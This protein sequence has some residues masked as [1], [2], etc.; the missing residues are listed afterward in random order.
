MLGQVVVD[1]QDVLALVHEVLAHSA[2]GIGGDILQGR[3]LGGGGRNYDGVLH[4]AGLG[5][6]LDQVCHSRALLAD[7]DVNADDVL[8]L[9]VDDGIGGDH[10]L[11]GLAVA[12]DQLA[13]AAAD[14]DHGVD[15][16]DAGLEGLFDRLAVD[17]AGGRALDGPVLSRFDGAC[18]VDGLAQG[19]DHAA[20]HALA[21]RHRD[22]P[23]GAL[24][25]AALF[26]AGVRAQQN[27]GDGV[28]LQ[29]LGHAV[30]AV[31]ELEQLAGHAGVQTAGA[32]D[33]VAHHD[34]GAGLALLD[35]RLV[36]FDL[37]A[38]DFRDLLWFQLHLFVFTTQFF[39]FSGGSFVCR[40]RLT[41]LPRRCSGA[42]PPDGSS[43]C[44]PAAR[45]PY[46]GGCRPARPGQP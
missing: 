30:L 39:L 27:D 13:L 45:R 9:L 16:L 6:G 17:D 34:D 42:G 36:V 41:G 33:A 8:A 43:R 10:R 38:D 22:N 12:N 11:T 4:G 3:Q 44:R 7:G 29:V 35:H 2:A 28:L 1:D 46:P 21:H 32:G 26:D 19:V 15:G 5:Q 23:A 31:L 14:G 40:T 18:A 25:H 24:D 20:N 37:G